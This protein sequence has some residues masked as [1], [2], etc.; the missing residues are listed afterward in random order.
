[1]TSRP[2]TPVRQ[3]YDTVADDYAELLAGALD[4]S[5]FDRAVLGLFAELV[6]AAGGGLVADAG[7]GPG[8]ITAHLAG[9]GLDVLGLDLSPRMVAA[10][11]RRHPGLP[12]AVGSLSALPLPDGSLTGALAWY[13]LI[14]TAPA[15]QPAVLAELRRVLRPGGLLLLAFQTGSDVP[16][17]RDGV[18][19]H[20]V[21]VVA[22]RLDADRTAQRL[23]AAGFTER[24]RLVRAAEGRES[25]P[26][27]YLLVERA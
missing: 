3:A 25:T 8:R 24:A 20:P 11:R 17:R 6:T 7:C 18:Y 23:A 10:A 2:V 14:H 9:L 13:S 22:W 4:D 15:D 16:V 1:M 19:G 27:A 12:F 5:P 26:Q 21:S